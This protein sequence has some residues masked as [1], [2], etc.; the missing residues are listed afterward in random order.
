MGLLGN[1]K[2]YQEL[3]LAEKGAIISIFAYIIVSALKL[4]I[5][6]LAHSEALQAD[7]LN[8]ATDI[9]ASISVLIGLRLSRKP[10]D[11]DHRYGH[12]KAENVA[13]L[14]TSLIMIVVSLQVLYTSIET[15]VTGR[16]DTPDMVAAIVGIF[17]A[18]FMY[19]VYLYNKKLA[20][21]VRSSGLMA[22]AKDNLSD[23]W[24]SIG[25]AIAVFAASFHFGWIDS[26]TALAVGLLILK[27]GI[28][29][30]KESVFS[31]SDGFD[32]DLLVEY[33][34]EILKIDGVTAVTQ[35]KGRNY[36]ANIYVDVTVLMP[37]KMNVE[38]S[39]AVADLIEEALY[40]H[41]QVSEVDVHVEP[42]TKELS[43]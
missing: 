41:H 36:G 16:E 39:H 7:G 14:V 42:D 34:A 5:G 12:W 27:T 38:E 3:K 19:G 37:A 30:F 11:D 6:N 17:S 9:V 28:D 24:T 26:L 32:Q 25:T 10:A 13:S 4:L 35:L 23:A 8:N 43:E 33:K 22:A 20:Q 29:I 2:R 31:L 18:I 15:I 40:T 21:S 1:E